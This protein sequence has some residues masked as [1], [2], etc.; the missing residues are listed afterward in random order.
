MAQR[1]SE[2]AKEAPAAKPIDL[3]AEY[4]T[5]A[6]IEA[7]SWVDLPLP[8]GAKF[9]CKVSRAT[10]PGFAKTVLGVRRKFTRN[11]KKKESDL[12]ATEVVEMSREIMAKAGFL[13]IGGPVLVREKGKPD[14]V[15]HPGC[16]WEERAFILSMYPDLQVEIAGAVSVD[17]KDF[18]DMV[19]EVGEG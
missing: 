18:A 2:Q 1:A 13:D 6:E 5:S 11:G 15:V 8:S 4:Q 9:K 12:T 17:G 7:G 3:G 14:R 16:K 19:A 10:G